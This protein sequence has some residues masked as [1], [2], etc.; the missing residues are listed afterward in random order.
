[1][2]EYASNWVLERRYELE[3]SF[4]DLLICHSEEAVVRNRPRE[5]ETSLRQALK[6]DPFPDEINLK[7]MEILGQLGRRNELTSHYQRY[8]RILSTELG[9]EPSESVR[10]LYAR[11]I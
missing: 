1:M 7:Y 9:L 10:D 2:P 8:V 4:L 6:I 3:R 5:A 11:L